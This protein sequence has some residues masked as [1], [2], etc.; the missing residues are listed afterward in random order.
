MRPQ[1]ILASLAVF[2]LVG[3]LGVRASAQISPTGYTLVD[4]GPV[5]G[6]KY[7]YANGGNSNGGYVAVVCSNSSPFQAARYTPGVGVQL[8][9]GPSGSYYSGT[10]AVNNSGW[11]VGNYATKAGGTKI[12]NIHPTLWTLTTAVDLTGAI[13]NASG[14]NNLASPQIVGSTTK[15]SKTVGFLWQNGSY[16]ITTIL[17]GSINDFS[18][19][20]GTYNGLPASWKPGMSQ[21]VYLTSLVPGGSVSLSKIANNHQI[22]GYAQSADVDSGGNPLQHGVVWNTNGSINYDMGLF[23]GG[24]V[25]ARFINS[26]GWVVGD[27]YP[28]S[29]GREEP[30]IWDPIAHVFNDV[31]D[32]VDHAAYPG[33]VLISA[34]G[35]NDS[36]QICGDGNLNGVDHSFLLIPK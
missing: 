23:N 7:S 31:N 18:E 29:T 36:G 4:L 20:V 22:V 19:I 10:S 3:Y 15:S 32:L 12:P 27:Y 2:S 35:I 25:Y 16:V 8:L 28:P 14:I 9:S 13:G 24:G 26:N 6:Y 33:W 21:P 34:N 1:C 30:F 17:G 11:V 5:S